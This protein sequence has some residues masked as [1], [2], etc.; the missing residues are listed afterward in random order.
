MTFELNSNKFKATMKMASNKTPEESWGCNRPLEL[1]N[2]E[3]WSIGG[4]ARVNVKNAY[5][6]RCNFICD[7]TK[8][9][10]ITSKYPFNIVF[11]YMGE[12]H[13]TLKCDKEFLYTDTYHH[14]LTPYTDMYLAG[15]KR[16][17]QFRLDYVCTIYRKSKRMQLAQTGVRYFTMCDK[18][19]QMAD[20]K[21]KIL[22]I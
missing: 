20:G 9:I 15:S 10:H 3:M 22:K 8:N 13:I 17:Q 5:Q 19:F 7:S 21:L 4:S 6:L 12:K 16:R 1:S 11:Y 2:R 14:L 18:H